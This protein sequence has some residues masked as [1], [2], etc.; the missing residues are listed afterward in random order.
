MK[1][2]YKRTIFIGLAFLSISAFWQLYDSMI[3]L[4]LQNNF[5]I[6]ETLAGL[7]MALDNIL[8]LFLLPY[9]GNLSDKVET[10]IGKRMPFILAGTIIA[11]SLMLLLT[12]AIRMQN[13]SL[14][15]AF[16]LALLLSMGLYRSPAVALMPDLTPAIFRSKANAI[17]NLMGALG[18]MYALLSIRFFIPKNST[19]YFFAFL[20]VAIFM[21]VMVFILFFTIN[22]NKIKSTLAISAEENFVEKNLQKNNSREKLPRDVFKSLCFL[23]ASIFFWF[24]AYNAITTAFSRYT[25]VVWHASG[26]EFASY[27]MIAV[28]ASVI[29]YVPIG[30]ISTRIGRKRTIL[31]GIVLLALSYFSASFLTNF[32]PVLF[33]L[34]AIVGFAWAAI[35]VNSYPMVV[36]MS[37]SASIGK[38]TGLYYTFSMA[39]QIVTPIFSGALLEHVSYK[40]L[41]P[42]S[43]VFCALAFFSMQFVKHGDAKSSEAK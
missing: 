2:N 20:S 19:N 32:H 5:G 26:G 11:S 38:Y 39:G 41:F 42:Y 16:L 25:L 7:I 1:L 24:M 36:E 29:S 28:I 34:L 27:L 6:K 14:F 9:F 13:F 10:R 43:T 30:F 17:I 15:I 40:T 31:I 4:V 37:S 21:L 22:E 8:A 12:L 35:N 3:P 18:A 23:L 33:L